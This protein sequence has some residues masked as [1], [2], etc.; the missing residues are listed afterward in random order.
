MVISLTK[1]Y[2]PKSKRKKENATHQPQSQNTEQFIK[3]GTFRCNF[4][5]QQPLVKNQTKSH[6]ELIIQD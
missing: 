6:T 5:L 2:L 4:L 1:A 3:E